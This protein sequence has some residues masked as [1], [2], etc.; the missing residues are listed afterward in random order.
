MSLSNDIIKIRDP[1]GYFGF[2]SPEGNF[3][4]YLEENKTSYYNHFTAYYYC[5][6]QLAMMFNTDMGH[7]MI[8]M[9]I[10]NKLDLPRLVEY[11]KGIE[12]TLGIEKESVF[13]AAD[14]TGFVT[15]NPV[16]IV[17]LSP[18]WLANDT[19]RSLVSLLLRAGAIY[20]RATFSESLYA[21]PVAQP[22]IAAINWFMSGN[23]K[24]TYAS[25]GNPHSP[26][27][28]GFVTKFCGQNTKEQLSKLLIKDTL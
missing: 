26:Y 14:T 15:R 21:Y 19:R 25:V 22:I 17:K 13:F 16:F 3:F 24:P 4:I 2:I 9:H 28:Q 20:P 8:G 11:W 6:D 27:L 10:P 1:S 7:D 12:D 5:R 23:T 18:F